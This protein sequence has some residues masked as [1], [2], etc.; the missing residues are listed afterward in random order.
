MNRASLQ[1]QHERVDHQPA[2]LLGETFT[3]A[4]LLFGAPTHVDLNRHVFSSSG[5]VLPVLGSADVGA[6]VFQ[7]KIEWD[8]GFGLL[9]MFFFLPSR[10]QANGEK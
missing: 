9:E 3:Y 10:S 1:Q 6:S 2:H 8:L 7:C 5:H 4:F